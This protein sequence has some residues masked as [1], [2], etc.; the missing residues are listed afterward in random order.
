MY[1]SE[2][3]LQIISLRMVIEMKSANLTMDRSN[4]DTNFRLPRGSLMSIKS[5]FLY[6]TWVKVKD[7]IKYTSYGTFRTRDSSFQYSCSRLMLSE[8]LLQ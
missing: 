8:N 5:G 2:K 7:N 4:I 3:S 1:P 6:V